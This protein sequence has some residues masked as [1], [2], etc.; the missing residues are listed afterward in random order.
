MRR[1][2]LLRHA[3]SSWDDPALADHDRPL[4]PRGRH[5]ARQMAGHLRSKGIAPALVLCSSAV[6]TRETLQAI[7]AALGDQADVL[8]EA[9]LFGAPQRQL[10]DRLRRLPDSVDSAMLIGH[11]P[12][13]QDLA[14]TLARSSPELETLELKFPT[15]ALATLAF[16]GSW[17]QLARA[18]ELEA[19][20]RP[21][22][23][24]P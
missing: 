11:N 17:P 4:A 14:L 20:V 16:E 18:A 8:F 19:F 7:E 3:K 1:L 24:R 21:K 9:E 10:L 2:Y 12:G 23:L 22:D 15:G 13:V 5:A 6:R